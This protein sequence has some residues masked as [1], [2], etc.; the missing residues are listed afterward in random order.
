MHPLALGYQTLGR[1]A[2]VLPR[3]L[4]YASARRL[5]MAVYYGWPR[6]RAAAQHNSAR[7]L[8]S[9][10]WTERADS[11]ALAQFRRYGE[12]LVDAVR[13]DEL[14]PRD[15]Y[16]AVGGDDPDFAEQWDQLEQ[17]YGRR[18]VLFAVLHFGNWDVLG[19]AFTHRI[20]TS[21]VLVDDLG[22][23]ALNRAIQDQR[24]RLGM[25]PVTGQR[26]LRRMVEHLRGHGTG[27]ILFD[28]PPHRGERSVVEPLFDQ[29]VSVPNVVHRIAEQTGATIVPLAATRLGHELRFRPHIVLE[30]ERGQPLLP[31]FES[32]IHEAPDQWYQFR[33]LVSSG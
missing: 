4:A 7:L 16:E 13:L 25:T 26:G 18:P 17:W 29:T 28:R 21:M 9:V 6:G 11:L 3:P 27:A 2:R 19:G 14:S 22:H 24:A 23:P 20:G 12:Y 15:C 10:D 8:P 5:M 33:K 1:L 30:H 32:A 31:A